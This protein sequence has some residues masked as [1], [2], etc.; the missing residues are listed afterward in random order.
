MSR[1]RSSLTRPH[2]GFQEA[3]NRNI[4]LCQDV[5]KLKTDLE[6]SRKLVASLSN[7]SETWKTGLRGC[8]EA[9]KTSLDKILIEAGGTACSAF[10]EATPNEFRG[11]LENELALVLTLFDNATD[12]RA[13]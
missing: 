11:W 13:F 9:V 3:L 4:D 5:D 10:S 12:F 2:E 8:M 1:L 7:Q 6:T